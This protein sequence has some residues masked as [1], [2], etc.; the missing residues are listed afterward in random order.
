MGVSGRQGCGQ[1]SR[2]GQACEERSVVQRKAGQGSG[3]AFACEV[4]SELVAPPSVLVG[5]ETH[6]AAQASDAQCVVRRGGVGVR[7]ARVCRT[8]QE[9][10]TLRQREVD[11]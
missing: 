9:K 2:P 4:S 3:R 7:V 11:G 1:V 5:C 8:E 10:C 6:G